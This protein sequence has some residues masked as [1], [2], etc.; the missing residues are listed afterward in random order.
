MFLENIYTV[1]SDEEDT[2]LN[3]TVG[4]SKNQNA[5]SPADRYFPNIQTQGIVRFAAIDNPDMF[6]R[7]SGAPDISGTKMR[8]ILPDESKRSQFLSY[9]PGDLSDESK[10]DIYTTLRNRIKESNMT[11]LE[12]CT[13]GDADVDKTIKAISKAFLFKSL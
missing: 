7:G 6:T 12:K 2:R 1:Y 10:E 3:Y 13:Y 5:P 9:L 11:L 8:D 4:R